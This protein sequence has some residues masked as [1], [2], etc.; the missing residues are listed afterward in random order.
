MTDIEQIFSEQ[1]GVFCTPFAELKKKTESIKAYIFDWDGVFN[2][3][4]KDAQGSSSFSEVDAMGTNLM[5]FSHYSGKGK[6]PIVAI[7]SG[8]V[9]RMSFQ[10]GSREHVHGI[11]YRVKNK[12]SAL[13]HFVSHH[14]LYSSEVAFVFDDVLDLGLCERVGV[15]F[16]INRTANPLF[17]NFVIKNNLA[18]YVTAKTGGQF[19]VREITELL[20]GMNGNFDETIHHRSHFS[21]TYSTYL[22]ERQRIPTVFYTLEGSQ[23]K[24]QTPA[25]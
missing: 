8:E 15:R 9:N 2:D 12:L 4:T 17:K 6:M 25:D 24:E 22:E 19:A 16:M 21:E 3:G 1:G 11:Y 20:M 13:E 14:G 18:D 10:M 7:M 23:I 5:R